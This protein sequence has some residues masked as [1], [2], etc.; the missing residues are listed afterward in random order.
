ML[1]LH[2]SRQVEASEGEQLALTNKAAWVET[3]AK[4]NINVGP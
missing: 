4:N 3:S 2:H 1:F